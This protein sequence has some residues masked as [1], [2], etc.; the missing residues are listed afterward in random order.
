MDIELQTLSL[1]RY[2]EQRHSSLK[3]E[4]E[5]GESSSNYIHQIGERLEQSRDN[6]KSIY[7]SAFVV[8]DEDTP[9]GYLYISSLINDEVFLEYAVL[10]DFRGQGYASDMVSETTEYLFKKHNIKSIRLDID[11]SNKNSML[12]ANACGFLLDDE[13]YESRN[14]TGKMQFIKESDCYESKRRKQH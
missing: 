13:D 10:K 8:L 1:T 3:E 6:D 2:D 5:N 11:P 14:L 12:V 9:V 7:Q 4:L